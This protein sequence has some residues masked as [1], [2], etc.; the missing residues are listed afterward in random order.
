MRGIHLFV[1]YYV[2]VIYVTLLKIVSLSYVNYHIIG[3]YKLIKILNFVHHK[4]MAVLIFFWR[5]YFFPTARLNGMVYGNEMSTCQL[6]RLTF[7]WYNK[8]ISRKS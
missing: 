1:K 3:C 5:R 6:S 8:N 2:N 7:S 4:T